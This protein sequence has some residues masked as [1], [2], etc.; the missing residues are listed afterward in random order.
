MNDLKSFN[1]IP[2]SM[3]KVKIQDMV[4]LNELIPL[5]SLPSCL[6]TSAS[7]AR[8]MVNMLFKQ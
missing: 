6:S 5:T 8:L 2:L 3:S 1:H 7:R 4:T